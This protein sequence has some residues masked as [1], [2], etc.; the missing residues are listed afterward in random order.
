MGWGIEK[1]L[2]K[3]KKINSGTEKDAVVTMTHQTG[4]QFQFFF[5][6]QVR[7]EKMRL[8]VNTVVIKKSQAR[9]YMVAQGWIMA[10]HPTRGTIE[11]VLE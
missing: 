4:G 1:K 6:Y 2:R 3:R 7:Q 5:Q 11:Y 10:Q 8:H 9:S